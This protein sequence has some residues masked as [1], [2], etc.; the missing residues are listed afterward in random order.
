MEAPDAQLELPMASGIEHLEL[1]RRSPH[2]YHRRQ[3][4]LRSSA[5][6]STES[7]G[8]DFSRTS[9]QPSNGTLSD[10][11][12]RKRR[13][14]S[15]SPSESGTEADDEGY[16]FIKAL[17]APPL[18]P[19]KGLRNVRG[20]GRDGWTTPLLTP[21]MLDEDDRKFS[22]SYFQ[23]KDGLHN[24]EPSPSDNEA[25]AARKKYL[26]RRRN[27]VI[28]RTTETALLGA[29]G[30]LAVIGCGCWA[31]LLQWHRGWYTSL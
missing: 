31:K 16:G 24:E 25:K 30:I 6:T 5:Q 17:P 11:H 27:E 22:A 19:H 29:I 26:K 8:N 1:F 10:E 3:T 12:G 4:E 23:V 15:Q 21:S 13:K 14:V 28:R 18:R 2:P 9:L 20:T 7:S